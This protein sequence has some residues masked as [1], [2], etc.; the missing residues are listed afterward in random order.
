MVVCTASSRA[1]ADRIGHNNVKVEIPAGIQAAIESAAAAAGM[2]AATLWAPIPH[3]AAT[4]DYP[5]GSVALI[6]ALTDLT[7][8]DLDAATL[9]DAATA[10]IDRLDELVSAD[11]QHIEMLKALERYV[12]DLAVARDTPVPSGEELA[13][14]F[15]Q[16]LEDQGPTV[17]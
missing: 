17:N 12:D 11:P 1:L 7:N 8:I 2:A 16:F 14:Q 5:A 9:R 10:S 4:M 6:E 3:Y 13:A 15:R